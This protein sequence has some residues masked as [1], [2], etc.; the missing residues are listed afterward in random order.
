MDILFYHATTPVSIWADGLKHRLP[1]ARLRK[2]EMGDN[3][4]AEYALVRLP[5]A[6]MLR[7]RNSLK[8]VFSLSAGVDDLLDAIRAD[9]EMM[10]SSVP[11]F[12]L[13]DA[14]M[15]VQMREYAV[16]TVLGWHRR[17]GEYR[18]M[19]AR[20]EWRMLAITPYEKFSVGVLGAGVL[21]LDVARA[22]KAWGFPVRCWSRSAK[23]EEGI[24]SYH[25]PDQLGAFLDGLQ[26]IVNV[27]P[28]TPGTRGIINANFLAGM[29]RG[30]YVL[31]IARGPQ[32]VEN[33][34]LAALDSGQVKA[35]ALDV[36]ETE[37]L[38]QE[39][40]F[41]AHPRVTVTPHCAAETIPEASFEYIAQSIKKLEAG[42]MPGGRVDIS[43]GY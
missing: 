8:A 26:V 14:G 21:G 38:P 3:A 10:P 6:A 22:L 30:A 13:E 36:F 40:P 35:A 16:H 31:N 34:L 18:E 24:A 1:Q 20:K 7:G 4:P 2:W 9:P 43:R 19:Q 27:L 29:N 12:R 42:E 41:W 25:G 32:L 11:L 33:D 15:A 37:P 5:P 17:F 28:D 23:H 39:H